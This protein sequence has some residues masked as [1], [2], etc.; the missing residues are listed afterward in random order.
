MT[1][2]LSIMIILVSSYAGWVNGGVAV[3]IEQ[4]QFIDQE[5]CENALPA[6]RSLIT[7][8]AL[9]NGDFA[10]SATCVTR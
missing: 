9:R 2:Y 4:V 1:E 7:V 6:V 3:E 10:I 8:N 5:T